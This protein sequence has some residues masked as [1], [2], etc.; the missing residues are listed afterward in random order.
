MRQNLLRFLA[1]WVLVSVVPA[2][3]PKQAVPSVGPLKPA[4]Q[5]APAASEAAF[6]KI[7]IDPSR[8]PIAMDTEAG[9][10]AEI[11]NVSTVPVR[12][13]ENEGGRRRKGRRKGTA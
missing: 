9:I 11:K 3:P 2:Q 8:S 6:L 7:T 5:T 1:S 10:S 4:G 12:L 13:Y